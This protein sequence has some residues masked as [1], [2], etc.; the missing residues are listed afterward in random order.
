MFPLAQV[1]RIAISASILV[2]AI[3]PVCNWPKTRRCWS[4]FQQQPRTGYLTRSFNSFYYL[5]S[6]RLFLLILFIGMGY[7][8]AP[9][10]CDDPLAFT[11]VSVFEG[12]VLKV[13]KVDTPYACYIITI[14]VS[15]YVKGIHYNT[16]TLYVQTPCLYDACCGI[17]FAVLC[18]RRVFPLFLR[19]T[20]R[21]AQERDC[22]RHPDESRAET[23]T[24]C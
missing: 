16:D 13:N 2:C 20:L 7:K 3:W 22:K 11:A 23:R 18:P 1:C 15:K 5:Y 17:P 12:E 19:E 21:F 4:Y 14:K 24:F 10:T 8:C 9:C 6:T